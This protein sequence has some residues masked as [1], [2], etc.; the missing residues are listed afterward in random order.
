[1]QDNSY[2]D[3]GKRLWNFFCKI[4]DHR[5]DQDLI[6]NMLYSSIVIQSLNN[7]NKHLEKCVAPMCQTKDQQKNSSPVWLKS[8]KAME[9]AVGEMC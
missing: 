9:S 8:I 4:K 1:M 6:V 5:A 7:W 3:Q 2:N